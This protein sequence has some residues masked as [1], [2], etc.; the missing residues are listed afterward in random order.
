MSIK[1][2]VYCVITIAYITEINNFCQ[3]NLTLFDHVTKVM[4]YD[5]KFFPNAKQLVH[6]PFTLLLAKAVTYLALKRGHM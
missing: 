6:M 1:L 2:F 4:L 3:L 5:F